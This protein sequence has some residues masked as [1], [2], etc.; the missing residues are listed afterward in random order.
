MGEDRWGEQG[1]GGGQRW[2]DG[3]SR[4]LEGWGQGGWGRCVA[5]K[6]GV[7]RSGQEK[8]GTRRLFIAQEANWPL[9]ARLFK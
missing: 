2:R 1:W 7:K 6:E 4:G 3:G 5:W 8:M 9:S